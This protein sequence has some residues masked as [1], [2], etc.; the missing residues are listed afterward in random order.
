MECGIIIIIIYFNVID[1]CWPGIQYVVLNHVGM[2][3]QRELLTKFGIF[4]LK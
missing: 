1:F 2:K 3:Q 4:P